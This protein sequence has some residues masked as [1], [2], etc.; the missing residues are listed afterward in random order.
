MKINAIQGALNSTFRKAISKN[1]ICHIKKCENMAINSHVLQ[2]NGILSG[3]ADDH[4]IYVIEFDFFKNDLIYFKRKGLNEAFTFKG[5]CKDHDNSIFAPIEDYE[6]DFEDYRNQLLFAYRTIFNEKV[7][8]EVNL[9]WR[10]LQK[11]SKTLQ[12]VIDIEKYDR[13]DEQ[14]RLGINDADFYLNKIESDLKN[15][16]KSFVF[17]VRYVRECE[18]CI[19]SS[20]TLETTLERY[21]TIQSTGHDLELTTNIVISF[22]PLEGENVFMIGYLK[23]KE[24]N[25]DKYVQSFLD[26]DEEYFFKKLS[27]L[28]LNRCEMWTCS[29]DFFMEFLLPRERIIKNILKETALSIRE[30]QKLSFNLFDPMF[31]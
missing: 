31:I 26:C 20:F 5:F 12:G 2:K 23:E 11:E 13:I 18:L 6:I 16:N 9:D 28:I 24:S 10:K 4:H 14:E 21:L 8:K 1:R 17:K 29:K 19:A 7:K 30:D 25:C 27:D 22:F 3:I 15:D